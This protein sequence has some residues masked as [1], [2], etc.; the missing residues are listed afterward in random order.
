MIES[1]SF[2]ISL[3][4]S[5]IL[6]LPC[7]S[8]SGLWTPKSKWLPHVP[9]IKFNCVV[10]A[11]EAPHTSSCSPLQ[12]L[13]MPVSVINPPQHLH[14][15]PCPSPI[16]HTK[17]FPSLGALYPEHSAFYP[18]GSFFISQLTCPLL[19]EERTFFL[20]LCPRKWIS[21]SNFSSQDSVVFRTLNSLNFFLLL[22]CFCLSSFVCVYLQ[23]VNAICI[24]LLPWWFSRAWLT[25]TYWLNGY[26]HT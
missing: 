24:S 26:V 17:L 12:P 16:G 2:S 25:V 14:L 10:M 5:L 23:N 3:W 19:R 7:S 18:A 11:C 8:R 1:I 21:H 15:P 9:S 6:S 4:L 20:T 22:T 13:L